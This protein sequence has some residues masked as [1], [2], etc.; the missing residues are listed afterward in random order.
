MT[1]QEL[2]KAAEEYIKELEWKFKESN[3]SW[4]SFCLENGEIYTSEAFLAGDAH[5]YKRAH[6]EASEGFDEW[7]DRILNDTSNAA[8][9]MSSNML[10]QKG[11]FKQLFVDAT[12]AAKKKYGGE[13]E[14]LEGIIARGEG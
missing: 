9:I 13:I 6:D 10:G 5:G 14:R 7:Y 12:I 3:I 11:H 4:D 1:P 8:W 2:Q